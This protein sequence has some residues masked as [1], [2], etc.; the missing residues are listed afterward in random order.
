MLFKSASKQD[1]PRCVCI[2]L[3]SKEYKENRAILKEYDGC[4]KYAT[5]CVIEKT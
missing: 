2:K 4:A 3:D 5:K 1:A